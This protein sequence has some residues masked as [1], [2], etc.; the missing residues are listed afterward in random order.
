MAF[1]CLQTKTFMEIYILLSGIYIKF[2]LGGIKISFQPSPKVRFSA[3]CKNPGYDPSTLYCDIVVSRP[4]HF[5]I[6]IMVYASSTY[7]LLDSDSTV[8]F[9]LF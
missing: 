7:P 5:L 8:V 3:L 1:Y 9:G 4:I 2:K 6:I